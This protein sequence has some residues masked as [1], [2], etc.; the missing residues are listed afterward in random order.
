MHFFKEL[1]IGAKKEERAELLD[2]TSSNTQIDQTMA[3]DT[4]LPP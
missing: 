3:Q 4:N 2:L 1:L